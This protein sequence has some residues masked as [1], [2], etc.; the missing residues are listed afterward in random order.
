[1]PPWAPTP[2]EFIKAHRD[3]LESRR[4]SYKLHHW[5]DLTF[6]YKLTGP[7]AVKA[8][9]V[10]L[11][12]ADGHSSLATSGVVQVGLSFKKKCF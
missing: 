7:A 8:K 9:N 5:I 1:M 3:Q 12:L 6:G 10:C 2:E 11:H 4:V